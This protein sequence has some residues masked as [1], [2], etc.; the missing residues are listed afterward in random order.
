MAMGEQPQCVGQVANANQEIFD[1]EDFF[2]DYDNSEL[3]KRY[4]LD[5]AGIEFITNMIRNSL[6]SPTARNNPISPEMKVAI[7]QFI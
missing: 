2:N 1:Q 3:I 6:R 5:L 4:R 7:L